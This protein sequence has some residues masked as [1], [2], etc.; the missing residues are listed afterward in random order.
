MKI[1]SGNYRC[2]LGRIQPDTRDLDAMKRTGWRDQGLLVVSAQDERLDW[3]EREIIQR[4][5]K[6]LYGSTAGEKP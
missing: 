6:R 2:P 4:I 1:P 3:V 5:G